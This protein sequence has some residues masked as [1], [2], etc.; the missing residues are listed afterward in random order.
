MAERRKIALLS[1]VMQMSYELPSTGVGSQFYA[2]LISWNHRNVRHHNSISNKTV[3]ANYF[4]VVVK[5]Y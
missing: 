5:L 4:G 2:K 3:Y 1:F